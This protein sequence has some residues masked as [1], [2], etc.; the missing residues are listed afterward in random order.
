MDGGELEMALGTCDEPWEDQS[1]EEP[2]EAEFPDD[3]WTDEFPPDDPEL[4][5]QYGYGPCRD[6]PPRSPRGQ[7]KARAGVR[8]GVL[9]NPGP[10]SE[11]EHEQHA[12]LRTRS[13]V[14]REPSLATPLLVGQAA[15]EIDP[16]SLRFLAASAL[17]ARRK[18]EERTK[19]QDVVKTMA[20]FLSSLWAPD[21]A[22]RGSQGEEEGEAAEDPATTSSGYTYLSCRSRTWTFS[23]KPLVSG[24]HGA[25]AHLAV[26]FGVLVSPAVWRRLPVV[27]A[28]VLGG[29]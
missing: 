25:R 20:D 22:A 26:L 2:E 13:C 4:E 3:D 12:S 1:W 9:E 6:E 28:S 19:A 14:S 24:S 16:S 5:D 21:A 15:E 23:A 17:A 10:R 18:E 11:T 27:H 8:P 29:L 7:T